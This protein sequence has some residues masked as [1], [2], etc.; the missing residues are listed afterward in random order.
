LGAPAPER[1]ELR[2]AD[3]RREIHV[4]ASPPDAKIDEITQEHGEA[5]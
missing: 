1:Y 3:Q 4:R 2:L 5:P